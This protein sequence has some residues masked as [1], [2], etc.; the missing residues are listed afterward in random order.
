MP[1]E[2]S[3]P[4]GFAM[5]VSRAHRFAETLLNQA[6]LSLEGQ[7]HWD[8][9]LNNPD[10]PQRALAEGN[11]GLGEAYMD[12]D[13]DCDQLDEFFSR[14]LRSGV[15]DRVSPAALIFHAL[16]ARLLNRQAGRRAWDVGTRHYD[17][18]N[19]FYAA[20]LDPLMTY[21]CGYWKDAENLAQAQEA[22]LDLICRKLNL[23]PGMRVL[24][25][26]CGWGSF[27]AYAAKHYGV[28]CVGVTIS[29]EQ[30][31][32][33][34]TRH[35]GLPLEFR[36]QDY[37]ELDERFERIVSIGMFEHVGRKN[38]RVYMET[39]ARCLDDE[40]LF[41]LHTIGKNNRHSTP[42]RW[43]DKYIFPN[44][45]LPSIG[46]IGDAVDGL[47]VVEDLHNF[48]ADYDKTLMAWHR[49]FEEAWPRFAVELG[50]RFRRMWR[51]YLLSCAGAFRARDIQLWQ[52]VLAKQGVIGG[53]QRVS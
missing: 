25:I 5:G 39:V 13:W 33:A 35:A 27:M 20:M 8:M 48:G 10:V 51:Y 28:E 31:E 7:A 3:T 34:K 4:S 24:D 22:K 50:E 6:G 30:C 12:G 44:G 47:F 15:A 2:L 19:D 9:R 52:W 46:Q 14:L 11:L 41:L 45:D 26:G 32:W 18:G 42:D 17:L 21:T 40:G 37:R 53:Y 43:I 1:S 36:L 29:R 49:H 23:Q 38:H 16:Q